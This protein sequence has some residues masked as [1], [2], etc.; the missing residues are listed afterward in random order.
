MA[1]FLISVGLLCIFFQESVGSVIG[2][3]GRSAQYLAGI[4]LAVAVLSWSRE[5]RGRGTTLNNMLANLFKS[6]LQVLVEERTAQLEESESRYHTLINTMAEGVILQD[7]EYVI[8]SLNPAAERILAVA[9]DQVVG[10]SALDT[11]WSCIREDGSPYP[12]EDHPSTTTLRTGESF[13]ESIMGVIHEDEVTWISINTRPL[14][15]D[16]E[17]MPYAVV[18]SFSDITRHKKAE[19]HIRESLKEKEILLKEIHHR[20]KNNFAIV[21]TL[22]SL[23]S[24]YAEGPEHRRMFKEIEGRLRSMALAHQFL[25]QSESLADFPIGEYLGNL[26]D[27][28]VFASG[29]GDGSMCLIKHFEEIS[30]GP[31][32]AIPLGFLVTELVTNCMKHA[33]HNGQKGEIT[34]SLKSTGEKEFELLVK[35]NGVGMPKDIDV[36]NPA[37]LGLDLVDTFVAQLNGEIEIRRE[38]GTEVR[39]RFNGKEPRK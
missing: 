36:K 13:S 22:V 11:T 19:D 17:C 12:V 35:D 24:G 23:Q 38:Q 6:R 20:V 33:F 7:S 21:Q 5:L 25:Y 27:H 16:G 31:D 2:W 4:Y 8:H 32:I 34:I 18:I 1:L 39:I 3:L 14:I 15:K 9:A 30:F 28:L 10:K 37:S 29:S 26:I